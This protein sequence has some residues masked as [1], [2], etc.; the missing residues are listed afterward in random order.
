[1]KHFIVEINYT[2]PL[3]KIAEITP[4]HREYLKTGYDSGMLLY[5]GRRADLKGGI[6]LARAESE[7][8]ISEFFSKDPYGLNEAV[9]YKVTE[10]GPVLY[11][12]W[13]KDWLEGK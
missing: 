3:E 10:F 8:E 9:E 11:Q 1:M 7:K 4:L 12:E 5:S 6:V 2:K 13:M